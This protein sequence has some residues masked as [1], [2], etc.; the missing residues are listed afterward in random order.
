MTPATV[1]RKG[2]EPAAFADLNP[3]VRVAIDA[4]KG[5]AGLEATEVRI[6]TTVGSYSC[7][8]HPEIRQPKPGRCPMCGMNLEK[9]G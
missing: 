7:P 3:G 4:K 9:K 1:Y 8:M 6:E 5:K 2:K